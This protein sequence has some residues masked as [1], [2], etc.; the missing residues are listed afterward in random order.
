MCW[1]GGRKGKIGIMGGN[2]GSVMKAQGDLPSSIETGMSAGSRRNLT[3][4]L[5]GSISAGEGKRPGQIAPW[6]SPKPGMP[7][8][9]GAGI[10]RSAEPQRTNVE[11]P[12]WIKTDAHLCYLSR[13]SGKVLEV[14]V[15]MVNSAKCEVEITFADNASVWKVIPFSVIAGSGNPLL[16]PW[17]STETAKT[18]SFS[19]PSGKNQSIAR[20]H[21]AS[22]EPAL[23]GPAPKP[24]GRRSRSRSPKGS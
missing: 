1:I 12:A 22:A 19:E 13:S 6:K 4:V 17:K 18:S 9:M 2:P 11:L 21:E 3:S 5:M 15:E 7:D 14:I 10:P 24:E 16:G 20:Y 23:M 8:P